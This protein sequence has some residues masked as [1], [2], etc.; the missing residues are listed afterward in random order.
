MKYRHIVI[1]LI[2]LLCITGTALATSNTNL[3]VHNHRHIRIQT[4][5]SSE[6]NATNAAYMGNSRVKVFHR[7]ECKFHKK[8]LRKNRIYFSSREEAINAGYRPCRTC[9]P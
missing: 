2:T 7:L 4:L 8:A 9:K 1:S 5:S 6:V 3:L